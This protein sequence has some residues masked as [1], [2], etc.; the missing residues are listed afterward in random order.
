MEPESLGEIVDDK[1]DPKAG[2]HL[3]SACAADKQKHP[4]D[5]DADEQDIDQILPPQHL[6]NTGQKLCQRYHD[7]GFTPLTPLELTH[8]RTAYFICSSSF[9]Q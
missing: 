7:L 1:D 8:I 4:V 3:D 9:L 6:T 2:E 5:D